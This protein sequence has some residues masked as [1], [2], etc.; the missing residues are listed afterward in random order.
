MPVARPD[1][2]PRTYPASVSLHRRIN[3]G[4]AVAAGTSSIADVE[5]WLLTDALGE[6]DVL[7]FFEQLCWRLVAAG[8]P[9]D[10]ASLH[11]GTL[12]PQLFGF[13]WNWNRVD[14]L[15]DEVRVAEA[16]L[17]NLK[18]GGHLVIV[19]FWDQRDL[20]PVFAAGL[21][22]W[23]AMFHVHYRP[24]VH[25]ALAALGTTGRADV[26][27]ESVAKRYAYIASLRKR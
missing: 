20:H 21:K 17:A 27:F 6:E 4:P 8:L 1:P 26:T 24:E 22:R 5:S 19:D 12:H 23:L 18:T 25:D 2:A 9:L 16:A 10:R 11:V 3:G 13:G 7:P 15:C 14:G